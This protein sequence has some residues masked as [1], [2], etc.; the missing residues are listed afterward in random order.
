M[1]NRIRERLDLTPSEVEEELK[2]LN[3]SE[4]LELRGLD[5]DCLT[6]EVEL[7]EKETEFLIG[8]M[9][10]Y[11]ASLGITER[12]NSD[13]ILQQLKENKNE[14]GDDPAMMQG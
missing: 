5:G 7:N 2:R 13:G 10:N 9:N 11:Y 3:S 8:I 14:W 1:A 12:E 6:L 4:E